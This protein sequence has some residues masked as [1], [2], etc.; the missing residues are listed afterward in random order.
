MPGHETFSK[1]EEFI[2]GFLICAG[3]LIWGVR[4][5]TKEFC[6]WYDDLQERRKRWRAER[7]L[8]LAV[9]D[10]LIVSRKDFIKLCKVRESLAD[11]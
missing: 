11:F 5:L 8:A 10:L 9:W 2:F 7:P 6:D 1:I 3:I 4:V